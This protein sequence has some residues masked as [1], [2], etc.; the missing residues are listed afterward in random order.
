MEPKVVE[1][2]NLGLKGGGEMKKED[3]LQRRG[4]FE[5]KLRVRE[6]IVAISKIRR[7][8]GLGLDWRLRKLYKFENHNRCNLFSFD[9]EYSILH[10][11]NGRAASICRAVAAPTQNLKLFFKS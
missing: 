7:G 4:S 8:L 10:D 2:M 9:L 6:I 11:Q 1:V 5:I 3:E